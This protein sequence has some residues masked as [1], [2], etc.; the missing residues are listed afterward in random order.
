VRF[1]DMIHQSGGFRAKEIAPPLFLCSFSVAY[2][3]YMGIL[4]LGLE[5]ALP[6]PPLLY[7]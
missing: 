6:R 2:S 4:A 1:D 7:Q 3:T 5:P